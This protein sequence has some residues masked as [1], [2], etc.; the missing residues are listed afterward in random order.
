MRWSPTWSSGRRGAAT[1]RYSYGESPADSMD[2]ELELFSGTTTIPRTAPTTSWTRPPTTA[3]SPRWSPTTGR[4]WGR[5]VST[6]PTSRRRTGAGTTARWSSSTGSRRR[7]MTWV[8]VC[9]SWNVNIKSSPL[10]SWDFTVLQNLCQCP[11][12][13][14]K[15]RYIFILWAKSSDIFFWRCDICHSSLPGLKTNKKHIRVTQLTIFDIQQERESG[16]KLLSHSLVKALFMG[17]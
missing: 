11:G 15:C 12:E 2:R 14:E 3:G 5:P 1:P 4:G 7:R 13:K 8:L 10:D 16:P 6:W 9:W 17:N